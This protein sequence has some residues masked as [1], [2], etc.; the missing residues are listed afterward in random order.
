M[1]IVQR[2]PLSVYVAAASSEIARAK[3]FMTALR[4]LGIT[5]TSTWTDVIEQVGAANPMAAA[6]A[7][8]AVW[9]QDDLDQVAKAQ[10]LCLL[11]PPAGVTTIGAWVELGFA[12]ALGGTPARPVL[13]VGEE[14]SIFTALANHRL[15]DDA[16]A[17]DA[18]KTL[19]LLHGMHADA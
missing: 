2:T 19:A 15:P 3:A 5:V 8:R 16:A 4:A 6:P 17:L 7:D 18:L 13:V 1:S 9:A 10:V 14:R 11:L 12:L